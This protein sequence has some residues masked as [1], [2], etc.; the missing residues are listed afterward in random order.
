MD[1]TRQV[2]IFNPEE[3]K[4][5]KIGVVGVGSVGSFIVL[6]L[7]KMGF[8]NITVWDDDTVEEHNLP[9]QFY[10]LDKLGQSKVSALHTLIE[11]MTGVTITP[12]NFKFTLET[13]QQVDILI[14]AVDSMEA[15]RAIWKCGKEHQL[16]I[17]SR[18]GGEY[19]RI[20][21]VKGQADY[22]HYEKSL[23]RVGIQLP[24]TAR[25][26]IYNVLANASLVALL[27]KKF[28]KGEPI[29]KE[30]TFDMKNMLLMNIIKEKL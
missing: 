11:Y 8:K 27:V 16:Y 1:Y 24:C 15:R 4:D 6:T 10:P 20:F 5:I 25:T 30:I 2:D 26:I 23:E 29:G 21:I 3:F 13:Y 7:T 17:D 12:I 18:M 19:I 22:A 14:S 9:N 28:L